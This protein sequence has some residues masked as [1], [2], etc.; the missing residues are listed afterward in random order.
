MPSQIPLAWAAETVES[1]NCRWLQFNS[2]LCVQLVVLAGRYKEKWPLSCCG[3]H[4]QLLKS[5]TRICRLIWHFYFWVLTEE[6]S[7]QV[8][9]D[10]WSDPT[11]K[12]SGLITDTHSST[13]NLKFRVNLHKYCG[14][15]K[16]YLW[17]L[18]LIVNLT[19]PNRI[20]WE[21]R[22]RSAYEFVCGKSIAELMWE[23]PG[24]QGQG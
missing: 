6:F 14:S 1:I 21:E 22:R 5:E 17:N 18:V 3:K 13:F 10:V 15:H 16:R 23:N 11:I 19:Q 12:A 2:M 4:Y 20:L 8:A 9:N 7:K 24:C